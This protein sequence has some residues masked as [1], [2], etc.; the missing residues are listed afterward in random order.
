MNPSSVLIESPA[1][2][3]LFLE[4][5]GRRPDG[6]HLLETIFAKISIADAVRAE[7]T[8]GRGKVSLNIRQYAGAALTCGPDNIVFKAA[9]AFRKE[10]GITEQVKISLEKR[11]PIGAGLGGGSSDAAAVLSAL[12]GVFNVKVSAADRKRLFK[13]AVS[14]G[15]D[16][17][18]FMQKHPLCAGRGIGEK[19]F[20]VKSGGGMPWIALAYPGEPSFTAQVYKRLVLPAKADILT[21]LSALH[22]L[23]K[24]LKEGHP[25]AYWGGCLFNRLE[26]AAFAL[27][28]SALAL[29]K[30]FI[31][32]G[33]G[34]VLM[35]GSGSSGFGLEERRKKAEGLRKKGRK[36]F[37]ARF[38]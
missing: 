5:I 8:G 37:V 27:C 36:I 20:P 26:P 23:K 13:I 34:A 30:E 12:C 4:V 38:L 24:G 3:N 21:S 32:A 1:K 22:K 31:L 33:A 18:F 14:L 17:P 16:V 6:Y 19:L 25:L 9:E 7:R 29:K 35:S 11:I 2:I 28:P 10:F 15:A